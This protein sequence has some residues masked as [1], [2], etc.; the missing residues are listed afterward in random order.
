MQNSFNLQ[1]LKEQYKLKSLELNKFKEDK[2][3][4]IKSLS[5]L[6]ANNRDEI[7][8]LKE[9]IKKKEEEIGLQQSMKA[10]TERS[11]TYQEK[12][13]EKYPPNA[14]SYLSP[15]LKNKLK[16][17]KNQALILKKQFENK[18]ENNEGFKNDSEHYQREF[19]RLNAEID[20]ANILRKKI[21]LL[22]FQLKEQK[23]SNLSAKQAN[24]RD[25]LNNKLLIKKYEKFLYGSAAL[26]QKGAS[27]AVIIKGLNIDLGK[28]ENDNQNLTQQMDFLLE[29]N[30]ELESKIMFLEEK[31]IVEAAEYKPNTENRVAIT[32]E[33]SNGLG[34]FLVTYSDLITLVLVIFVLLY[35]ISKVDPEKFSEAFSSFQEQELRYEGNNTQLTKD[36]LKML[37]RV[38]ELVKDNV[39]P[40]SL[41]RSDVRTILIR[42][43]S[44]DLFLPGSAELIQGAEKLILNSISKDMRD[45]VKQV[46][47]DG[48][49]DDVPMKE[50]NIFP[51]NWELSS[52]RASHVARVIIDTLKFSPERI[53]VTGYGQYRPLK[54]NNSDLNRG[55]NR[56]VEIK[57]LK[58]VKIEENLAIKPTKYQSEKTELGQTSPSINL[59]PIKTSFQKP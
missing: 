45:G 22:K 16:S 10:D 33:F 21:E 20:N 39:D 5:D 32:A 28:K 9:T 57:I 52:V 54:P 42:L 51:T 31:G 7:N 8:S 37:K 48:H 17:L 29:E 34:S 56:R 13:G 44:S 18:K 6:I 24:E 59:I 58:D 1:K 46:H 55:L 47:V 50:N 49:T 15:V 25:L 12:Q 3:K 35:S 19:D 43:K 53:V 38:R 26:D 11:V 30:K 36:E 14:S 4:T 41:V 40:E 27:P 2:E 23:S